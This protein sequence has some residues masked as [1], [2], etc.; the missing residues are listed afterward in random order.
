[1]KDISNTSPTPCPA[2][3][4]QSSKISLV[5]GCERYDESHTSQTV[6]CA[7]LCFNSGTSLSPAELLL[8]SLMRLSFRVST[9]SKHHSLSSYNNI[10][11]IIS[12]VLGVNFSAAAIRRYFPRVSRNKLERNVGKEKGMVR[13][14]FFKVETDEFLSTAKEVL[15]TSLKNQSYLTDANTYILSENLK[16]ICNKSVE[17]KQDIDICHDATFPSQYRVFTENHS[18]CLSNWTP[19]YDPENASIHLYSFKQTPGYA[20]KEVIIHKGGK[21]NFRSGCYDRNT[22]GMGVFV[23][24]PEKI[25]RFKS[26]IKL[27]EIIEKCKMC[28]G[29]GNSEQFKDVFS[30]R[31]TIFK[32]NDGRD[33]VVLEKQ[34]LRS[35]DCE[36]LLKLDEPD[37]CT[38][39]K[40]CNHYM[41]TIS[42]RKK[43]ADKNP[44][45]STRY[46]NRSK[47]ELV[48]T[49]R[50]ASKTIKSLKQQ[51]KRS[52]E[53]TDDFDIGPKSDADLKHIFNDLYLGVSKIKEQKSHRLCQWKNCPCESEFENVEMLY[54]HCKKH[55]ERADTTKIAPFDRAYFCRWNGCSKKFAKLR[56]LENHIREHTGRIN[57]DFLEILL[58]D[59]AKALKNTDS[60]QMRWHP[61]VIKWCLRIYIKSH[62]LYEDI[63]NSGGFKLPSGRLLS[64]YK[65]FCAPESGWQTQN[66]EQMR[67]QFKKMKPPKH[68]RL[69]AMVFDEVKIKEG[70]VFDCKNWELIGFTDL[71]GDE[72]TDEKTTKPADNLATHVLQ[73]FFRSLFFKFDYPCA[74]FLTKETTALQLNRI[75]WLGVSMLH[76]YEFEILLC[77][78]DGASS[79][80]SFI[81][82]NIEDTTSSSCQNR[83]SGM[84]IFFFSD[85]PHLI[86]KLRNNIHSS[87]FKEKHPRYSRTLLV[88]DKHIL[89][90]HIY[91]VYTRETSRHLYVTDLRKSHVQIDSFSK[92][93]VKLAVQ[94]LSAKVAK[95]MEANEPE[96]TEQTRR[97]ITNCDT[98]WKVFSDPK[99]LV[100]PD[101]DR[102][103]ELENVVKYFEDW[104]IWLSERFKTKKDQSRHFISWQLK[105]DLDVSILIIIL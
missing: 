71:Q 42:S 89:W 56:L 93:R 5:G 77:C 63:R 30:G 86:K 74:F 25:L 82:M 14:S 62:E 22:T 17:R 39:C 23:G 45:T 34:I 47:E 35:I 98:F 3:E 96:A 38:A 97:Y 80:R 84:P 66:L 72:L 32:K 101:D 76:T 24:L 36:I 65:N 19:W 49:A 75:F 61:L 87:G 37:G 16:A 51:L 20:D 29:C 6:A 2:T 12:K 8:Y 52:N 11:T 58:R 70:L 43:N 78:C 104:R 41:R 73:I 91:S 83:F 57:D 81:S 55:I 15:E 94:T 99:P 40:T 90:D 100:N 21:W 9:F 64:D 68:A 85:P 79:N 60:R 28:N 13:W 46:D 10:S 103:T 53:K 59:Q 31:E 4:F 1:M 105:F 102:I 88:D 48:A 44:S 7:G 92:M 69:G 50:E 33:G 27:L 67:T 54:I 26:L 95:E 18:Q